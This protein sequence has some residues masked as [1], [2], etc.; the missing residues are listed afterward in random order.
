MK[1][2]NL[3]NKLWTKTWKVEEEGDRGSLMSI[4]Q[5]DIYILGY[6]DSLTDGYINQGEGDVFL[7]KLT[8]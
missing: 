4:D 2:D 5:S 3:G 1:F 7:L 6:R 8:K